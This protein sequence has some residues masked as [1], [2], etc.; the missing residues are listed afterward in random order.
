MIKQHT[1]NYLTSNY[2]TKN[3]NAKSYKNNRQDL[4]ESA[5]LKPNRV[6]FIGYL[7]IL[8]LVLLDSTLLALARWLAETYGEYWNPLWNAR[9]N[10]SLLIS[11]V[12]IELG[13]IAARGLYGSGEHR[14]DYLNVVKTLTFANILFLL[15]AFLYHPQNLISRSTFLISWLLS[16]SFVCL[17]RWI[18]DF[19]ANSIYN[20]RLIQNRVFIFCS[21]E[22]IKTVTSLVKQEKSNIFSGWADLEL[23]KEKHF[24][25]ALNR[26]IDLEISRVVVYTQTCVKNPMF[27]YWKL[28]NQGITL[29]FLAFGQKQFFR[30]YKFSNI[31]GVP[32]IQ[33][34]TPAITG[35][36]FWV[37][38][39][40]DFCFAILFLF[41]AAPIY[42][43]I[44]LL[45]KLDS[46]GPIFYKQTRFGLKGN[47]FEVWKF[48]TMVKNAEQLQQA[49]EAKNET[50]DGILFKIKQDPRLTR[51]GKFL[52][53]Y[54][55][56]ELPQIF[57]ILAGE[58][59]FVGPRPLP[60][61]DV[62]KFSEHHFVRHEVL[63]GITGLWQISGRSDILNFDDVVLLDI[64]Y[65]EQWSLLLDIKIL[66]KTIQVVL[67]KTGAY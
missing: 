64:R 46:D 44:A 48:R 8:I 62:E 66:L 59:S 54:S 49:L 24:D 37:K 29:S 3:T 43:I 4:R 20:R 28:R 14:R 60:K 55:L 50:N 65:I 1:I 56:D 30:K 39:T 47:P 11:L 16:I 36:D 34:S 52:R 57:N 27:L 21:Q 2:S 38:R 33:F 13:L 53:R 10:T 67:Q 5:I 15:L 58:M 41:L 12:I 6:R 23:L 19:V 31:S 61:R 25:T 17:G 22:D 40:C 51:V 42:L 63:P 32:C 26:M 35:L 9:E 18:A 45:I 7:R